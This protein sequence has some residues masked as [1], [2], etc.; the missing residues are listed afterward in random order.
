MILPSEGRHDDK[1]IPEKTVYFRGMSDDSEKQHFNG[2]IVIEMIQ[3]LP[4]TCFYL[5][6][7]LLVKRN[8][9]EIEAFESWSTV[10][11]VFLRKSRRACDRGTE[12]M[13]SSFLDVGNGEV[14]CISFGFTTGS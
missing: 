4:S 5:V 2:H 11:L 3:A 14:V 1:F 8:R 10:K 6:T 9:G 7:H 13:W 12:G